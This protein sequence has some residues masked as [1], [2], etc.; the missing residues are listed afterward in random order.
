MN[1][2]KHKTSKKNFH[3]TIS[4]DKESNMSKANSIHNNQRIESETE[5][6]HIP[7]TLKRRKIFHDALNQYQHKVGDLLGLKIDR[8]DASNF[9]STILPCK[10]VSVHSTSNNTNI[11]QLCTTTC[12]FSTKFQATDLFN[13]PHAN[14]PDVFHINSKT[15]PVMP[16]SQACSTSNDA[17][18]F[19]PTVSCTFHGCC[20][21]KK[22][23]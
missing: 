5:A 3:L 9:I 13:L 19:P 21:T 2:S 12:I 4:L 23:D 1:T 22:R 20:R 17:I 6:M 18:T 11:Y 16:F 10:I 8:V 15:S 7:T 14:F